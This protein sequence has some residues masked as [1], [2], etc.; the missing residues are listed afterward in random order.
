MLPILDLPQVNLLEEVCKD[1]E[2]CYYSLELVTLNRLFAIAKKR[3]SVN[4]LQLEYLLS[5]N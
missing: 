2:A 1:E 5:F 4:K 3:L